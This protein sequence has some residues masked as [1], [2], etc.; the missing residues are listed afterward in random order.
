MNDFQ[1]TYNRLRNGSSKW[2]KMTS[3][4]EDVPEGIIPL[5]V[6]DMEFQTAEVIK[7]ALKT[8]IDTEVLGYSKPTKAYLDSVTNFFDKFHKTKIENEWIVTTPGIVPALATAVRAFS[9]VGDGVIIFT[10]VYPPFYEVVRGQGRRIEESPLI[11]SNNRY[12]IDFENLE[13]IAK[14]DD[15]KLILFC[16]PHNPSGIVWTRDEIERICQIAKENDI[17]LVSDEIHSDYVFNG[18][19]V[20]LTDLSEY[21]DISICCTAPS[22]TFNI[23]GLQCS[24]ILIPDKGIRNEFL[25]ANEVMGIERANVL[26]LVAAKACYDNGYDWLKEASEVIKQNLEI[27]DKFFSSLSDKFRVM[28]ID[29]SFLAWINFEDLNVSTEEFYSWLD[30]ANIFINKGETFGEAAKY[31][32]RLNVGLPTKDLINALDRFEKVF[33]EKHV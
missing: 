25:R 4:K 3:E 1:T 8:Y 20:V 31:F 14:K 23:A 15:V 32:I 28:E 7:E 22:K 16:N 13:K 33:K 9:D 12:E 24:N 26:G 29:A 6:A 17:I 21:R 5:S 18:E 10:P 19:H 27:V 11:Y 2:L 30:E